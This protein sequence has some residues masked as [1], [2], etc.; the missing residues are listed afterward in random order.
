MYDL[1]LQTRSSRYI[2]GW[3]HIIWGRTAEHPFSNKSGFKTIQQYY[4]NSRVKS[5]Y[6]SRQKNDSPRY[7]TKLIFLCHILQIQMNRKQTR[8]FEINNSPT[9]LGIQGSTLTFEI[10]GPPGPLEAN[11]TR[12]NSN[13][14]GPVYNFIKSCINSY[15]TLGTINYFLCPWE[16]ICGHVLLVPSASVFVCL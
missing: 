9:L 5:L 14:G 7:K 16:W 11:S 2:E 8:D 3:G 1:A 6:Y 13:L 12:P 10:G 15:S 4:I